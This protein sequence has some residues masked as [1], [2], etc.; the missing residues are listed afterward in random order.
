MQ[1]T[2]WALGY[3]GAGVPKANTSY[4]S[5]LLVDQHPFSRGS[6]VS[7]LLL[8]CSQRL[9]LLNKADVQQHINSADPLAKPTIDPNYFSK[10]FGTR[11]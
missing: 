4:V 5:L 3:F 10:I 7:N 2:L 6:V 9:R 1:L 8:S 11:D